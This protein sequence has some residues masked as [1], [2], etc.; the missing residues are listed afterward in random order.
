MKKL[1]GTLISTLLLTSVSF[2]ESGSM[3]E[4]VSAGDLAPP[5]FDIAENATPDA[6]TAT[7]APTSLEKKQ[8]ESVSLDNGKEIAPTKN[9]E[10]NQELPYNIDVSY[11]QISGE[12]LSA[13]EKEFNRLVSDMVQ[14]NVTQFKN[15]VKADMP[16]M[17]TLPES[18]KHNSLS[19]DYDI[20]VIK[21]MNQT[22]ISI[23]LSIEGMQ[24]GRAHPY[25]QHQVLNFDLNTGKVLTLKEFFK[26]GSN[27]LN[28]ISKRAN[29][30]LNEKL[31]DK[32][33]I[34]EGTAPT[35]KN[36]QLWNLEANDILITFDEYQ[37][38]PYVDG[39]QEVE[40]PYSELTSL[41]KAKSP[42]L[43]CVKDDKGCGIEQ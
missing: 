22:Y 37:V 29:K 40:I 1:A 6:M 17:Q 36:Y 10:E 13:N 15:Y 30:T 4:D 3:S 8:A 34:N 21:P 12:N 20:D 24:A 11:P 35:D 5:A 18:V 27:Y 9:H 39:S 28:L 31:Q 23:R 32:W 26:P 25:H 42:L 33:M 7:S 38:A 16:H 43:A 41:L 14:K 19:I 2:A